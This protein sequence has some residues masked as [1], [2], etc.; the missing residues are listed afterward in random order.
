MQKAEDNKWLGK[1][2]TGGR[3]NMSAVETATI[4]EIILDT[5]RLTKV[6]LCIH[7]DD[8]K[9]CYD[10]IIRS[11]AILNSRK[12]GI[13]DNICRL[14]SI[15]HDKMVFKLRINNGI[16]KGEYRSN[17]NK[18]LHGAGQGAGNGGTKWT[19]ISVPMI[20]TIEK[21]AP[22]CVLQLPQSNKTWKIH[23]LSFV[24]DKRYYVNSITSKKCS[25]IIQ[26]MDK[27]V[28]SWNELLPFSGGALELSKCS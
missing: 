4:N 19:F 5:H 15:T 27:S 12:F 18:K 2:Q 10:Q 3:R 23:M 9:A 22:G 28:S 24:D 26:S 6:S 11:H 13:P 25:D 1:N 7:Q 16:F 21:V 17:K 14:Y 8:A 20:D